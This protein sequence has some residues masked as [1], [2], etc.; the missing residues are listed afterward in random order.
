VEWRTGFEIENLGF[1]VY[2]EVNGERTLLTRQPVAGSALFAGAGAALTAGKPY[3]YIDKAAPANATYWI[4]DLDLKGSSSLFGPFFAEV[5]PDSTPPGDG[6]EKTDSNR[7]SRLLEDL[8]AAQPDEATLIT[9]GP[10]DALAA[11]SR[12]FR[13]M[14]KAAPNSEPS[15]LVSRPGVDPAGQPALKLA[16]SRDGWYRAS[17]SSLLANG[18]GDL[19][20]LQLFNQGVEIPIRIAPDGMIEFYGQGLDTPSTDQRTYWLVVGS[21]AGQRIPQSSAGPTSQV[22]P[23]SFTYTVERRD[24]TLY[25]SALLNG[26]IE[27]IFGPLIGSNSAT[28]QNLIIKAVDTSQPA[29]LEVTVQGVT[30]SS[31]T[32]RVS[33]A[34][35]QLGTIQFT[36]RV[37]R[38][39]VFSVSGAALVEGNNEIALQSVNGSTDINL[40]DR[41]RLTYSR[42]YR[43]DSNQLRFGIH[44]NQSARING[45]TDSQIKVFDITDP[46]RVSELLVESVALGP[47]DFA[48]SIP[49]T[50]KP[51]TMLAI[52]GATAGEQ[53]LSTLNQPSNLKDRTHQADLVIITHRDFQTAVAPLAAHR[54]A[55]GLR[56]EVVD[57]EDVY[58]EFGFGNHTPSAVR[59]FLNWTKT[60]WSR[61]PRFALLV[62]DSTWDPRNYLGL[63]RVD[64]VPTKLIDTAL[65]E[66]ASDDWLADFNGDGLP[67]IALGR[68]PVRTAAHCE[69]VINKLIVTDGAIDPQRGALFVAD[70]GFEGMNA[71][72]RALL[73]G[74]LP[75]QTINRSSGSD[76]QV[77]AQILAALNGGPRLVNFTGHGSVTVWTGAGLL[78]AA[79]GAALTNTNRLP[80]ML[81]LTCLNGYSHDAS[82]QS[83]G[84][85]MLLAPNGA[86]AVWT[87]T[88]MTEPEFQRLMAVRLFQQLSGA[89]GRI[90]ELMLQAKSAT[91]D[92]DVRRTWILLGDPSMQFRL[93]PD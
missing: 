56:V 19:A 53:P 72:L 27:N 69:T 84:E 25:F 87:S 42:F 49:P 36:G 90:G 44:A 58:D 29:S 71:E 33:L 18:K 31:H 7:P 91:S 92:R 43:A 23:A 11:T 79:D 46:L 37:N 32:V 60:Q 17:P 85:A 93:K 5:A 63:G 45:F 52:A 65:M 9:E 61:A 24:R 35:V 22:G 47:G 64:F 83:L 38:K 14:T 10:P 39:A 48:I 70:N 75:V 89:S 41:V 68:L 66:T 20:K 77:R 57:I 12:Q 54:R 21:N 67:E 3:R 88:G 73:P 80:L 81:M 6:G 15:W 55:Q 74:N 62:G 2:R 34:G 86:S 78:T 30:D 50:V 40:A 8:Q 51:R 13:R 28:S 26:E 59:E 1:N 16:V 82:V 4:E 76:P